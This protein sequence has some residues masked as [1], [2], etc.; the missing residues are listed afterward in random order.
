MTTIKETIEQINKLKDELQTLLD[1][2]DY[3]FPVGE[4]TEAEQERNQDH[5]NDNRVY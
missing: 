2:T 1:E 5:A 4:I 3:L